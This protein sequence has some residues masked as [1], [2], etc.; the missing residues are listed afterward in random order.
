M[1]ITIFLLLAF[2]IV[3]CH[4]EKETYKAPVA[5]FSIGQNDG[6]APESITFTNTSEDAEDYVWFFGD[7]QSSEDFS[8]THMYTKG[9]DYTVKLKV[10]GKGGK[11]SVQKT[12]SLEAPSTLYQVKNS[13][14]VTLLNV[15]S[16]YLDWD[17]LRVYDIIEH[18]SM[19]S[20]SITEETATSWPSIEVLFSFNNQFFQLGFPDPIVKDNLTV[21][22]IYDTSSCYIYDTDPIGSGSIIRDN[23]RKKITI[24]ELVK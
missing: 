7:G 16:F 11:D 5:S 24:E 15:R 19:S 23:N 10:F 20:G 22:T 14:S 4:P 9:G 2:M 13:G 6:L 18:G 3:A 8:P 17:A 12:L 21:I 1:R